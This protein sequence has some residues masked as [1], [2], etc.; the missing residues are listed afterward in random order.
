MEKPLKALNGYDG[1]RNGIEVNYRKTLLQSL[2]PRK[3][4]KTNRYEMKM[5]N[6]G[7]IN[8]SFPGTRAKFRLNDFAENQIGLFVVNEVG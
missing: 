1:W 3:S 4:L 7:I 2:A 5:R 6:K 8:L